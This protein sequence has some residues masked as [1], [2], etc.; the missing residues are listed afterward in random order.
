MVGLALVVGGCG[1]KVSVTEK[2]QSEDEETKTT[3][4]VASVLEAEDEVNHDEAEVERLKREIEALNAK[5]EINRLR[6]ELAEL[7][8]EP[9]PKPLLGKAKFSA[10]LLKEFIPLVIQKSKADIKDQFGAPDRTDDNDNLWQYRDIT[11]HPVT[12]KV[13]NL[14]IAFKTNE[15]FSKGVIMGRV[16]MI[17]AG[18]SKK[19]SLRTTLNSSTEGS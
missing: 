4:T 19:S 2:K 11:I 12:E 5:K 14:H 10:K 16:A 9:S 17:R 13:D 1:D 18:N 7:K 3:T 15:Y 8:K 6:E